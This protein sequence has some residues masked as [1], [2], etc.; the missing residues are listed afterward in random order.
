MKKLVC[1]VEKDAA[2]F[3]LGWRLYLGRN[4]ILELVLYCTVYCIFSLFGN[5]VNYAGSISENTKLFYIKRKET[6]TC[7]MFL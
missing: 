1:F 7:S 5:F 6:E 4:R 3:L 2:P